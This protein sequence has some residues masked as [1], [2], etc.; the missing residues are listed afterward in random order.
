MGGG[1]KT[2]GCLSGPGRQFIPR[3]NICSIATL[4][5]DRILT[6]QPFLHKQVLHM[7][8]ATQQ[9]LI[10]ACPDAHQA[11]DPAV[12]AFRR[13]RQ[14]QQGTSVHASHTASRWLVLFHLKPSLL[15][16]DFEMS[17]A[18]IINFFPFSGEGLV[19]R[20]P[21]IVICKTPGG[22]PSPSCKSPS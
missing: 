5:A 14:G 18:Q 4:L 20:S 1:E 2:L 7:N 8:W 11:P 19:P 10:A 15:Q 9:V 12:G 6:V 13:P 3:N 16:L 17:S 22:D 21:K